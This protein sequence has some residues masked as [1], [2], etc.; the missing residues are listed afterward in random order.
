[1]NMDINAPIQYL[2]P[3]PLFLSH[4]FTHSLTLTLTLINVSYRQA[5]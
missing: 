1:M 5:L 2:D 4:L 3:P